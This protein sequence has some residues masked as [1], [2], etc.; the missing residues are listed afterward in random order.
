MNDGQ[1]HGRSSIVK[2]MDSLFPQSYEASR[3]RFLQDVKLLRPK[4]HTSRLESHPLKNHPDLSIDWFW[5]EPRRRENLIIVSTGEHGIEGYVGSA[6][7]KVFMEEFSPRISSENTGLLLV[8]GIN[9]WG[10]KHNRKVN[11]NGVDLNRNFVYNGVFDPTNNP[12]FLKL[13]RLLA[14]ESAVRS[15]GIETMKFAWRTLMVLITKGAS[16]LTYAALLGQYA[17]P[18][19][20]YFGGTQYEEG[21]LVMIE[22]LRQSLENYQ[23]VIHLDMHSGYGPRYLMNISMVPL[24]PLNSAQLSEKFNYPLVLR[25]DHD[26][27]YATQGDMTEYLYRLR[28]DHFSDKHVFSCVFEF[29]TYGESLLARL[30]SLRTM[31]FESQLYWHGALDKNTEDKIRNEFSELYFPA[32]PEWREKAFADARQALEGILCAYKVL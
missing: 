12:H 25:S 2:T 23:T 10:M 26:E 11:E 28:D 31:I 7:L 15:F 13:K 30:H 5:A 8:H 3:A 29:G 20:M 16:A 6:M 27:F 1:S 32:E 17:E 4:W 9:P 21:S 24:E 22:L 14:P 19:A 18:K